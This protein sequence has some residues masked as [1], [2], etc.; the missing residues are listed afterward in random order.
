MTKRPG[1]P[2]RGMTVETIRGDVPAA[3]MGLA[4]EI[5]AGTLAHSADPLIT[6]HVT[7]SE[8]K[9]QGDRWVFT[10]KGAGHCDAAYA[11]AGAVFLARQ[12]P[13]RRR[14]TTVISIPA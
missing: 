1:W 12:I 7:T 9:A 14:A 3:C 6:S 4:K 13:A 10:R 8:R 5:E 11:T 2:P